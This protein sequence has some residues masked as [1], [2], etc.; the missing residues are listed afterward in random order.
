MKGDDSQWTGSQLTGGRELSI[1]V[2]TCKLNAT[3]SSGILI[4][5]L[6][7]QRSLPMSHRDGIYSMKAVTVDARGREIGRGGSDL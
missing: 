5:I 7:P 2:S 3:F 4:N 1:R 6:F